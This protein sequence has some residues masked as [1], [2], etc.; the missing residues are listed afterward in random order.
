MSL[1]HVIKYPVSCPP[2]QEQLDN[3]PTPVRTVY[4]VDVHHNKQPNGRYK[5]SNKQLHKRLV[6]YLLI[7]EDSMLPEE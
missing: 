3:L 4:T 6:E 2:T 1:F 7:Y 5:Y